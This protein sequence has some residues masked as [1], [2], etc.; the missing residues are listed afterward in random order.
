MTYF[1]TRNVPVVKD[2]VVTKGK[3]PGGALKFYKGDEYDT[4]A[5]LC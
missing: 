2:Y 4:V 5:L 1:F 3:K